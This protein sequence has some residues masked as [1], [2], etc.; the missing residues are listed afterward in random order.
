VKGINL[1]CVDGSPG[2]LIESLRGPMILNVWGSWCAPCLEE[3][4]EFV[5]FYS[6]AKEKVQLVGIAVEE[7]S[8][9]NSKKFIEKHGMTWPNFY[10]RENETRSY[11]GMGVP[12]TWFIDASGKTVFKKIGVINSEAE[13]IELT[14]KYLGVKI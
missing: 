14:E 1:E 12:V 5:S 6:K 7:S 10:D 8:P 4:P 9:E 11:F 2:A 13:L 3:M